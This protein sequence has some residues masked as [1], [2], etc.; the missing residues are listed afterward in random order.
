MKLEEA[1]RLLED[2][3]L[4]LGEVSEQLGFNS[5]S[6]FTRFFRHEA[7]VPPPRHRYDQVGS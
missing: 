3:S 4:S 7:G 2:A 1:S 5:Q 6:S